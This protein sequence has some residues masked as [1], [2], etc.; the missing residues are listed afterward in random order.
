MLLSPCRYPVLFGYHS[1]YEIYICIRGIHRYCT[2][3]YPPKF[4]KYLKKKKAFQQLEDFNAKKDKKGEA[5]Q[6]EYMA[7]MGGK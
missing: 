4:R 5:Y 6:K 1:P 3:Q 7:R 2:G